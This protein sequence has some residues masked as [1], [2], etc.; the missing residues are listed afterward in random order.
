MD[1]VLTSVLIL[2]VLVGGGVALVA[3]NLGRKWGKKRYT[4]HKRIR[5]KYAAM[6]MAAGSGMLITL[7]TIIFV[8]VVSSDMRTVL[9]R[10][11]AAIKENEALIGRN[12]LLRKDNASLQT[13]NANLLSQ[14]TTLMATNKKLAD[15]IAQFK[16]D[17]GKAKADLVS[18]QTDRATAQ[19]QATQAMAQLATI[20]AILATQKG[21]LVSAKND[22]A[23]RQADLKTAK[24]N[25]MVAEANYKKL[26][27]DLNEQKTLSYKQGFQLDEQSK[28][29][30]ANKAKIE[31][32]KKAIGNLE[33]EINIRKGEL[34]KAQS[35]L[36]K[37]Q[38]DLRTASQTLE[39][40]REMTGSTIQSS[41]FQP[42]IVA[43]GEELYR[44]SVPKNSAKS[45]VSLQIDKALVSAGIAAKDRGAGRDPQLG[46]VGMIPLQKDG[47]TVSVESQKDMLAAQLA[48]QPEDHVL[49]VVSQFNTFANETIIVGLQDKSNP[50]IY[51]QG[52]IIAEVR[53]DGRK[54]KG[55]ILRMLDSL[56]TKVRTKA[57][58]DKMIPVSA[59]DAGFGAVTSE[60]ILTLYEEI[61]DQNREV[62]VR[63]IARGQ[64]RAADPLLVSFVVR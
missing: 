4:F 6:I 38:N 56:G 32:D 28:Q 52:E 34:E 57:L 47:H 54:D 58:D 22:L 2:F 5:P 21:L 33:A 18:A 14:R 39:R 23:A 13:N 24:S 48:A 15:S 3:D 9:L 45:A 61:K 19:S 10:G 49:I 16:I 37:A 36:S 11:R 46:F 60:Q 62:R 17:L 64:I 7:L 53:V 42:L 20:K 59:Q 55:D 51:Q 41:R 31:D 35:D 27:D 8:G 25:L 30:E 26:N 40:I 29:L 63:A 43:R 44:V 12:S 50:V 1:F